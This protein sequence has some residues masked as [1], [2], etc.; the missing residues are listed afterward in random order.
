MS[1]DTEQHGAGTPG[2]SVWHV[3]RGPFPRWWRVLAV[4]VVVLLL[5]RLI[6]GVL[7]G[8]DTSTTLS[9]LATAALGL[10]VLV[11]VRPRTGA[12]EEGLAVRGHLSR[13]RLVSWSELADVRAEGG[14]WATAVTAELNDG[15]TMQL[16]AVQP[17]QLEEVRAARARF[18]GQDRG[19]AA[20]EP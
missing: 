10:L 9:A 18:T 12:S 13:E 20:Q 14:R 2:P 3:L 6:L 16:P 15:S 7:A 19:T 17:E 5:L 8:W 4:V 1:G 11:Q